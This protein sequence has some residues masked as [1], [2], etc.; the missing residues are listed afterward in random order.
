M[1]SKAQLWFVAAMA[2]LMLALI[3]TLASG[4]GYSQ[5][6]CGVVKGSGHWCGARGAHSWDGNAAGYYNVLANVLV[7]ERIY[8]KP[9]NATIEQVCGY[10]FTASRQKVNRTQA[11]FEAHVQQNSGYNH[12]VHG[13]GEA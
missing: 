4:Y 8:Y 5:Q 2:A 9:W 6:Y 10:G 3:P 7:C 13:Y 1:H 11:I 12:T